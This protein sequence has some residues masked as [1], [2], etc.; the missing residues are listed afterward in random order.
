MADSK[1]RQRTM[2]KSV[3]ILTAAASASVFGAVRTNTINNAATDWTSP[4]S[5]ADTSFAPG[6]GDAVIVPANSTARLNASTDTASLNLVNGLDRIIFAS[7]NSRL[8]INVEGSDNVEIP[9]SMSGYKYMVGSVDFTGGPII[10]IGTGTLHLSSA[11]YFGASSTSVYDY[12]SSIVASQGVL[13]VQQALSSPYKTIVLGRVTVAEG[14]TFFPPY[15]TVSGG[16]CC[17]MSF[18]GSG[19][20]T[21]AYSKQLV[22]IKGLR[23]R[24]DAADFSGSLNGDFLLNVNGSDAQNLWG[25]TSLLSSEVHLSGENTRLG[26]YDFGAATQTPSSIGYMVGNG[27][28]FYVEQQGGQV[29]YLGTGGTCARG[30]VLP[31]ATVSNYAP[32]V[33]NAGAVGGLTVS[34]QWQRQYASEGGQNVVLTGS[35]N[36]VCVLNNLLSDNTVSSSP[37]GA[38]HTLYLSKEGI[39]SWRIGDGPDPALSR[40]AFASGISVNEGVFQYT[41]LADKG[42]I[43][44]LGMGTNLTDGVR[45]TTDT[46]V[47]HRVNYGIRLGAPTMAGASKDSARFEYAGTGTGATT[48][49]EIAVAGKGGFRQNGTAKL[50]LGGGTYGISSGDM[51][52]YLD[53]TNT[54]ENIVLDVSDGDKGGKLSVV[55]ENS[56]N[57]CLGGHLTFTGDISVKG[58]NLTLRKPTQYNWYRWTVTSL[59]P[60]KAIPAYPSWKTGNG[61]D[62]YFHVYEFGLYDKDGHNQARLLG[63]HTNALVRESYVDLGSGTVQFQT[64]KSVGVAQTAS[65][66]VGSVTSNITCS[67]DRAFDEGY[68]GWK[69]WGVRYQFYTNGAVCRPTQS[70]PETWIPVTMR[71]NPGANEVAGYDFANVYGGWTAAWDTCI[72]NYFIEAS[73]DGVHWD[74]LTNVEASVAHYDGGMWVCQG[75]YTDGENTHI[76]RIYGADSFPNANPHVAWYPIK[77]RPDTLPTVLDP[78]GTVSVSAGGKLTLEAGGGAITLSKVK[79]D[80]S[81]ETGAGTIDGF[82]FA[83]NGTLEIENV[84]VSGKAEIPVLFPNA[85]GLENLANW[86]LEV[87]GKAATSDKVRVE[88]G[89]LSLVPGGTILLFR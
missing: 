29:D 26:V 3:F 88:D 42:V 80:A 69:T 45:G 66:T 51:T 2:K 68:T 59:Y 21:N 60:Q 32:V 81:P 40:S 13:K 63:L 84:P 54:A 87:N 70:K 16:N 38:G 17:I 48:T 34:G 47:E 23:S 74:T 7:S 30:F 41:S 61:T 62:N 25:S 20:V 27:P 83:S 33:F 28:L 5:Y 31:A 15:S 49:R 10:K 36:T 85:T 78:A 76:T 71:L 39:G 9:V 57:W 18:A 67:L 44:S 72:S 6:S 53:G 64:T 24:G 58:G 77:G 22:Y 65:V 4:Q 35:N 11:G 56:G 73:L 75:G 86:N 55:K 19:T 89:K 1:E 37:K 82:A 79:L 52:L 46:N 14:A 12:Y 43:C 8:E 50:L